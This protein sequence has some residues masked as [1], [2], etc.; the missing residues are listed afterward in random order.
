MDFVNSNL[1]QFTTLKFLGKPDK[2]NYKTRLTVFYYQKGLF[3]LTSVP[4]LK[5]LEVCML[6]NH[7][8]NYN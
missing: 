1:A 3:V 5:T 6:V 2:L 8:F 7:E 4:V